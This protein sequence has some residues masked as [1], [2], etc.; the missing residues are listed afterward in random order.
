M[1]DDAVA[2]FLDTVGERAFDEPFMA[3]LRAEGFTD[4]RLVHGQVEFGKDVIAKRNGEQWVFQT[5]AGDLNLT[6]FRPVR[7]Q[8]YD[9]RM[10]D[11]S[12]PGFDKD[13]PRRAVLVQTGRMTGQAPVVAQEYEQQCVD[14]GETPIEFWNKDT[15]LTRLSGNP[16]A[17]L[18]GSM[19]GQLF[20]LLGAIDDRSADMDS[21]EA[22]SRRWTS[23]EPRRLAGLGVIEAALV[24]ERLKASDRLD[25]ACHVALCAVRGAW[26]SGAAEPDDTTVVAADSVGRLFETYARQLWTECDDRLLREFG[27]AGYSGFASW[28]TYSIRCL[29]LAE[30]LGLLALR[31]R[32]DDPDLAREIADWLARFAEAQPGISRP[33]GDR[34]A[35]SVIPV[36]ALLMDEHAPAA[37]ALLRSLT[38]WVCDRHDTGELGLAA[39]NA[40]PFEEVSRVLG[41][42]FEHV[43]LQPRRQS[44]IAGV[45]LDLAATLDL[46]D[47]YADIRNDTLAVQLYPSVFLVGVG[48]DQLSITGRGNRWDANP[49]FA[50]VI[51]G[52]SPVAPHLEDDAPDLIVPEGRWWDLL[53]VSAALRDRHFTCAIRSAAAG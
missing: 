34:Y 41:G 3:M 15:L 38:V 6:E 17:V 44:Q 37:E 47:V 24:C 1:L 46:R 7:D 4:V 32:N 26:A 43:G 10:S 36:I 30:I 14:R 28:V 52:T 5:K 12:A 31:V 11:L 27:L 48:P 49:D 8:L 20:G 40:A 9:L 19:D 16:D 22:F 33:I 53:A 21:I 13:L 50:E 23:W 51:D 18:R 39:V 29:R 35:V 42:P 45:L 2:A 25:L